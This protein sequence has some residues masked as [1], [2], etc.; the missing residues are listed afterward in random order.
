M[1]I[2]G[3]GTDLVEIERIE[4]LLGKFPDRFPNRVLTKAELDVYKAHAYPCRYLAKRYAAKEAISKALGTGIR[5]VISFQN[6]EVL[7]DQQGKPHV[8][9]L[10]EAHKAMEAVGATQVHISLSDE[11]AL[12]QA[13]VVLES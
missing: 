10:G 3:I 6:F 11:K 2:V 7:N 5:G 9:V 8:Q 13:F 1:P 4:R 12:A